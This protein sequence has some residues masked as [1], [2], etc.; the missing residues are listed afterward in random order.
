[1]N[2]K[3]ETWAIVELMGHI[4]VA[5]LVTEEERFG[6]KMG[7]IDIPMKDGGMT[8]QYFGGASVYRMTPVTEEVARA[9]SVGN[10]PAPVRPW[11]MPSNPRALEV[12][13][14]QEDLDEDYE[15]DREMPF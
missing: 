10:Q 8:T 15:E 3:L 1:M 6:S 5:G 4:K 14:I 12:S 7:R 2:S 11:E 9:V 13:G